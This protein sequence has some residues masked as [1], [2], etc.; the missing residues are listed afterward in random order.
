LQALTTGLK[1]VVEK[2]FLG[3]KIKTLFIYLLLFS[4]RILL[5]HDYRTNT[6]IMGKGR[7]NGCRVSRSLK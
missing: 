1:M 3:N 6:E 2:F 7:K 5:C 4:L